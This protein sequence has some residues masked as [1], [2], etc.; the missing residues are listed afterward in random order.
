M[1]RARSEPDPVSGAGAP[2]MRSRVHAGAVPALAAAQTGGCRKCRTHREPGVVRLVRRGY[3]TV[4]RVSAKAGELHSIS[5]DERTGCMPPG[6]LRELLGLLLAQ[7]HGDR[8][9]AMAIGADPESG[10]VGLRY[11]GPVGSESARWWEMTAPPSEV[12]GALVK[13]VVEGTVFA[14]GWRPVG[15]MHVEINGQ[16]LRV[17]VELRSW[18]DVLLQWGNEEVAT[19]KQPEQT[20]TAT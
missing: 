6:A 9:S 15:N 4:L 14:T 11:Y 13:T 10:T 18:Y 20:A 1:E 17:T 12:Y 16:P 2:E 8:M 3:N 7:A 5:A 19:G